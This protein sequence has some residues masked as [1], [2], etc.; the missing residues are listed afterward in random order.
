MVMYITQYL[1]SKYA[2]SVLLLAMGRKQGQE[3]RLKMRH[4][5]SRLVEIINIKLAKFF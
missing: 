4:R 1:M 2:D 5:D 3:I